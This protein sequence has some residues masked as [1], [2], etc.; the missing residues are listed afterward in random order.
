MLTAMPSSA[1]DGEPPPLVVR[2]VAVTNKAALAHFHEALNEL[3]AGK[4]RHVRVYHFGDSNVAADLW[5]GEVR[6]YFQAR[7]GDAG[8]GYLLPRP[9][10]SWHMGPTQ[11]EVGPGFE[12]RRHGFAKLFGPR[13]GL[14]G[15]AGAAMEGT[16]APA[17]FK[18]RSSKVPETGGVFALHL[19][20]QPSGGRMAVAVGRGRADRVDATLPQVGLVRQMWPLGAGHHFIRAQV[21]SKQPVRVLGMVVEY[22]QP[23][24]IYDTLGIN[25]HRVTALN[26]WNEELLAAQFRARP[27]DLV[28]LSYGGNEGLSKSLTLAEYEMGLRKAIQRVRR[29]APQA[30]ALLVGPVAMCPEREKVTHVAAIQKRVAPEYSAGFWDTRQVSGGPGS[31]C[32]W[33][34]ADRTLVARDNLHLRRKGYELI[35]REFIRAI[36]P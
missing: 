31:L 17:W 19:L 18:V 20:G 8:P 14:W 11:M 24:V 27:P 4:R 12:T 34:A 22:Q 21:M 5:T 23:G 29:L 13:D 35:A 32:D 28:V 6:Q 25:G 3:Q 7:Y 33:I 15:I 2:P 26:L 9:H 1:Q 30:S 10:G 36:T 16:G